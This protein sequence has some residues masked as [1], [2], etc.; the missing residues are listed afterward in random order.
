MSN[1]YNPKPNA[2]TVNLL[3]NGISRQPSNQLNRPQFGSAK[4]SVAVQGKPV[5]YQWLRNGVRLNNGTNVNGTV[6]GGANSRKLTLTNLK[7]A[8]KGRYS[9]MAM[10]PD[11]SVTSDPAALTVKPSR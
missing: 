5:S 7:V 11:G 6:I 2:V 9:V 8:D 4:F 10:W 1:G 3:Y